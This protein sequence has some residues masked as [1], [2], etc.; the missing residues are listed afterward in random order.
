MKRRVLVTGAAG[1]IGQ[2][3]AAR[4]ADRY[5]LMLTDLRPLPQSSALPFALADIAELEDLHPLCQNVDTVLHLAT[6]NMRAP[7]EALL[8]TDIIGTYNILLAAH[9]ASCRRVVF[10]SS[11]QVVDDTAPDLVLSSDAPARPT[12]LYGASKAWGEAVGSFFSRQYGLSV[13]CLRLGWVT[14]G[15]SCD[16][17]ISDQNLKQVIT[18][19]D[20]LSLLIAAIEAPADLRFAVLNGVS[21]NRRTRLDINE[22]R[23]L[24]DYAPRDDAFVLAPSPWRRGL[25]RAQSIVVRML[26]RAGR[27][28]GTRPTKKE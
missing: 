19:D 9:S 26:R 1:R 13:I 16:L 14:P 27:L 20:L 15:R 22:T 11:I 10:A 12:T 4:L 6:A 24:L 2:W 5:E 7:W 18:C 17:Y 28:V 23:R 21:N 8:P 3:V 25:R